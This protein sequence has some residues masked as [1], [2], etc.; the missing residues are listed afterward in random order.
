[1]YNY[2][3][4]FSFDTIERFLKLDLAVDGTPGG[5]ILGP[6]HDDGGIFVL[7]KKES[8][9]VLGRSLSGQRICFR[10]IRALDNG[11]TRTA[12]H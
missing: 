5:L 10:Y 6:S 12:R 2:Q 8:C 3:D 1:M 4:E 7:I 11:R 9:Y